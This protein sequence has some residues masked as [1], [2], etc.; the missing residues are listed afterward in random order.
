MARDWEDAALDAIDKVNL[1]VRGDRGDILHRVLARYEP[2]LTPVISFFSYVLAFDNSPPTHLSNH[3]RARAVLARCL[4]AA[5]SY[6]CGA[7]R[8]LVGTHARVVRTFKYFAPPGALTTIEGAFRVKP[9]PPCG[10]CG[11]DPESTREN[12]PRIVR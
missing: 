11:P 2:D 5:R 4:G 7:I 10:R 9:T 3:V 12:F 6:G 8:V 1:R